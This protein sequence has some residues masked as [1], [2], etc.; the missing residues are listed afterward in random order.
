MDIKNDSTKAD[1]IP[2][3][4]T[5]SLINQII[6]KYILENDIFKN[7]INDT[8]KMMEKLDNL[9]QNHLIPKNIT[10]IFNRFV[11]I[12][13]NIKNF[14]KKESN[15]SQKA[16]LK[17]KI[18]L[19]ISLC[20]LR[21]N[22]NKC[23]HNKTRKYLKL[24]LF[25]YFN[26]DIKINTFFYI[27][28]IILMSL[29][30]LIQKYSEYKYQIVDMNKEPL[31]FIKD[32]IE[33][34]I[35]FPVLVM[36]DNLFIEKLIKV[37]KNF[38]ETAEK[39][40]IILKEDELWLKLFE[41]NSIKVSFELYKDEQYHSSIKLM[42]D[43]LKE[44]YKNNTPKKFYNEIYKVSCIDSV[45]YINILTFLKELMQTDIN[46]QNNINID[47]G[48]YLFG[49]FYIQEHLNF[50]F[51]EFSL[52]TSFQLFHNIKEVP[53]LN[54]IRKGNNI[55]R[56][57]IKNDFL[58][59][60]INEDCK[61]N[62]NFKLVKKIFYLI[63]ITYNKK[64]KCL[65]LFINNDE[66]SNKKKDTKII[67]KE[68]VNVPKFGKDMD[69][70]IGDVNLY[71]IFGDI[72]FIN[73]EFDNYIIKQLFDSKEYYS[74][75]I[76]RSNGNCDLIK[77]LYSK[78]NDI[79]FNDFK[80]IKYEYR[81]IFTAN[82]FLAKKNNLNDLLLEYKSKN[83]YSDFFNKNG[84]E[85]LTFM[86]YNIDSII[87]DI[88]LFD[89]CLS[90]KLEFVSYILEQQSN[91]KNDYIFEFDKESFKNQLNIFF[92]TLHNI[93]NINKENKKK[94]FYRILSDNVW[95]NLLKIY[96][97]DLE[98]SFTYKQ[99]I[100]SILLDNDLFDQ[101]NFIIQI[102]DI[103]EKIKIEEINDELL[104]KIF[105]LDFIF[106]SKD[107]KH[108]NFSNF[109]N[110]LCTSQNA[111]YC[112]TLIEYVSKVENE[113][114]NYYYL[115]IIY[116]N[117]NNLKNILPQDI[118]YLY[119]FV[120]TQLI[121]R[122]HFHCEYCLYMIILCYLIKQ[123]I[124]AK[125]EDKKDKE[126]KEEIKDD[127]FLIGPYSFMH[128]PS[129]LFLRTIFIENFDLKNEIKLKFIISNNQNNNYFEPEIFKNLDFHPFELYPINRF[130][131]RF[132]GILKYID[133][134]MN[135]EKNVNLKN[136]LE[137]F[138]NFII[139]FSEKIKKKYT[140][141]VFIQKDVN[142][143]VNEFF[144]S[145]EFTD[146]FI[147][148]IK[149]NEKSALEQIKK[150]IGAS[151]FKNFNPFYFRLLN[152][153]NIIK[154][155]NISNEIKLKIIKWVFDAIINYKKDEKRKKEDFRNIIIFLILIQKIIN[156]NEIISKYFKKNQDLFINLYY[157]L[158][159]KGILLGFRKISSSSL[160][161]SEE[162]IDNN[163][164]NKLICEIILDII[165]K[166]FFLGN[167][168]AQEVKSL[169]IETNSTSSI[170]YEQDENKLSSNI[171][172]NINNKNVIS[173]GVEGFSFCLYFLIYFLEKYLACK[174]D[175]KRNFIKNIIDIIFND[176]KKLYVQNKK[177]SSRL[178]MIKL[179][180]KNFY[181]YN[182]MMDICNKN[183]KDK[184][185]NISFLKEQYYQINT[186][187]KNKDINEKDINM[188]MENENKNIENY[189]I[190]SDSKIEK[191]VQN[192]NSNDNDNINEN[193]DNNLKLITE[194][195]CI[196]IGE[197]KLQ[198]NNISSISYLNNE[199]IKIDITNLYFKSVVEGDYSK[200]MTKIL[201]NPKEYYIW[202]RFTFFFKNYIF[203]NKK[204][205]KVS[206]AFK[207]KLDNVKH[208]QENN[209]K[210]NENFHLNYPTKIKNYT[211]DEYYRPFLKPCMNFFNS[212]YLK[213]THSYIK[214]N[215]LKNLE[216]KE[217]NI[218]LIKYKRIIPKMNN[219]KYS[220]ELFKNK[221]NIF[222]YIELNKYFIIFKNSSK[223]DLNFSEDSEKCLPFL[224][225][226]KDDRIID[227][228]KYVLIFY[229]D[230]KEIIKRRICLLYI[231]LEIFLKNNKSYMF[232]FFDK[233]NLNKFIDEIKQYTQNKNQNLKNL[234]IIDEKNEKQE[235][236][237]RKSSKNINNDLILNPNVSNQN[238]SEINF[239]LIEDPISEFKKL[240]LK[241][242]N[243]KGELSNFDY[244]LLINKY[245]SRTYNDYNQYL[246][247]PL[248]YLDIGNKVKRDL[249]KVLCL[250]KENNQNTYDRAKTNYDYFKYHFDQHYSTSAFILYYLVRLI[251][252]TYQHILF[253]SMKF[254]IATRLFASLNHIFSF[255][256]V[257]DDNREL[258]PEFYSSFDF[259]ANLNYNNL[260]IFKTSDECYQI[261]N[262]NVGCKYSF[263]E[264]II[265]SRNNLEQSDL[266]PWIDIIFGIK[267]TFFSD[268]QPNLFNRRTYEEYSELE[269]I[270]GEDKPLKEKV[271]TIK[272]NVDLLKF[273]MAPAKL[274]NKLH[275]KMNIKIEEN[276]DDFYFSEKND[277][278][279]LNI[280]NKY[281][282]KKIKEKVEFY[283][284]NTKNNN[285][286]ELIFK[287]RNKIDIFKLKF[288]EN[289]YI[290]ISQKI[291]EQ[292]NLDNFNNAFC[293]VFSD[294]YCIV[295][296]IDNTI[297]FI[298]NQNIIYKYNFYC[299]VTAVENKYNNNLENKEYKEIFLGDE[300]G[301]L[302]LV[303]I[304]FDFNQNQ[305][306]Y[307]IKYIKI[308][309]SIKTHEGIICG[310]LHNERLNIIFSWSDLN[311]DYICINN[312]YDL[313][314]INIIKIEKENSIKEILV[315]KYDLIYISCYEKKSKLYKVYCFTLNGILLSFYDS[316]GEIIKCFVDEKINIVFWNTNGL[317]F[318][319]YTFDEIYK[320]FY[321]DFNK[322]SKGVRININYCQYYPKYQKYLMVC[323]NNKVLFFNNDN[324]YV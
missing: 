241:R 53:I 19:T 102:N 94:K 82:L 228:D 204:F 130:L 70:I 69:T 44:I 91:P 136:V 146:F 38:F 261:N 81:L 50:S 218:N 279:I 257:S 174:E 277:D 229:D 18:I 97:L 178:K 119:E 274:F 7:E 133:F 109:I 123:E 72:F 140:S 31:L 77:N 126:D 238:K 116:I 195:S 185:F 36:K 317:T 156:Q 232:N 223:D 99:I 84:F 321:C 139:D 34:I 138:F 252:F 103:F 25:F 101:R 209:Y 281:I 243:K 305:K 48:V 168:N 256:K 280:I 208:I 234:N 63:C 311:E 301:F 45:Y 297:S 60:D 35:N 68:N 324:N 128:N 11:K 115:K 147:L 13:N 100:L 95:N 293:E 307:E 151:L 6:K 62:T 316:P 224:F 203:F 167:Y 184:N 15:N 144:G 194:N 32:I 264:F 121:L 71:A 322:D 5:L 315:S 237:K 66:I 56:L 148:Y 43:F 51:N 214:E 283:L 47:K 268:E 3:Q 124:I 39:A 186:Q 199:L 215:I 258:I 23:N 239:R 42:I 205:I 313:N 197:N 282:H 193:K 87:T 231:G 308:K 189:E 220:C 171:N 8:Q 291:Q 83:C 92:L 269:K 98:N 155:E 245:S 314:L 320:D 29:V 37:F 54:L 246:I 129:D 132:R 182:N 270:K 113:I 265:K 80:I 96:S 318:Y 201:L 233:N 285:E 242:K 134:L 110:L 190:K 235:N 240:N 159:D 64:N 323:T 191:N 298:S 33:T 12:I 217:E 120:E 161:P 227:K 255:L 176:L 111:K 286:I 295:R 164:K 263:P 310:L 79:I 273:G 219:E 112:K 292:I 41:N 202:N 192:I 244:L 180:G 137:Y 142:K 104:Y 125:K 212:E 73:K 200:E 65:K 179:Q 254:D 149:F 58:N 86:L 59:I 1:D 173:D 20:F 262:V 302:H 16:V 175:D 303:E 284:I 304:K 131:I 306:I 249:S 14:T 267:Q 294:I 181:I 271:K 141:N 55:F 236:K 27:L 196:N 108:K 312:D 225:S 4:L 222:G 17:N 290:E 40:N 150:I 169:F 49:N 118:Y 272:E 52:I 250:N 177:M 107:N 206:K 158:K 21:M 300:R 230:I 207:I 213:I 296:H 259:M 122:D 88:K 145:K 198:E 266:S 288:G 46:K 210:E 221:G 135:L 216:Y 187:F 78:N 93:L 75:I 289:K 117:I 299:L 162:Y 276:E 105:L 170:F 247:F 30:N 319:L 188:I 143:Y 183:Y 90:K 154:E 211:I 67:I 2:K 10:I 26:G 248:L 57:S 251:P 275:E 160:D 153:K 74:N 114:K 309:K 22:I 278:K 61:W 24:L 89:L 165:F 157:F 287:Y 163:V 226:F 260:G 172:I 28:E 76:K 152:M 253:Q 166:Y 106:E 9:L 85:F 127:N